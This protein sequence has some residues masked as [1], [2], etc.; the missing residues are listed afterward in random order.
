MPPNNA[1][2]LSINDVIDPRSY[3][4]DSTPPFDPN[5]HTTVLLDGTWYRRDIISEL[6]AAH[7]TAGE[8]NAGA[9]REGTALLALERAQAGKTAVTCIFEGRI[10]GQLAE[11]DAAR[12][13]PS[14]RELVEHRRHLAVP[15]SLRMNHTGSGAVEV[16]LQLPTPDAAMPAN[17]YPSDTWLLL[18]GGAPLALPLAPGATV[19]V[20]NVPDSE[21]LRLAVAVVP[22]V[23]IRARS[24]VE[25][26][27][28]QLDGET[29]S[30]IPANKSSVML[31]VVKLLEDRGVST[32]VR[33]S[34]FGTAQKLTIEIDAP[35]YKSLNGELIESIIYLAPHTEA[36]NQ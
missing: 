26:L 34:V 8:V 6:I 30:V 29:I 13:E 21:P 16:Y 36:T 15:A 14:L 17:G 24:A 23:E 27:A 12:L 3:G 11:H 20:A 22:S 5:R 28:V 4:F 2:T 32:L 25:S 10:I 9:R 18:P 31:P 33:C 7:E 1:P 19:K 35:S